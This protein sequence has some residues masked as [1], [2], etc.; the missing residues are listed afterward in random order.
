MNLDFKTK[1]KLLIAGAIL[2]LLIIWVLALQPTMELI[3]LNGELTES[4]A[5]DATFDPVHKEKEIAVLK[6]VLKSYQVEEEDWRSNLWM[7][8][9]AVAIKSDI[10]LE[11]F[12]SKPALAGDSSIYK[13]ET[14]SFYG[15][16]IKLVKL[17]DTL[18]KLKGLGRISTIQ[19]KGPEERLVG[20]RAEQ[21]LLKIEWRALPKL[22][23]KDL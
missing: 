12:K 7:N 8:V 4:S 18:E 9:S 16:Y 5:L 19:M 11:Y 20:K 17:L 3:R 22:K 15:D 23:N 1:N 10:D 14:I 13:T 21:C 2:G 6:S